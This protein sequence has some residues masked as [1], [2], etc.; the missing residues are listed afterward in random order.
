MAALYAAVCACWI[1]QFVIA[2]RKSRRLAD[3]EV[4]WAAGE[5]AIG[6]PARI[7]ARYT[8][9]SSLDHLIAARSFGQRAVQ[10]GT[11]GVLTLDDE[12]L[13]WAPRGIWSPVGTPFTIDR[14]RV[15]GCHVDG[16]DVVV[17]LGRTGLLVLDTPAGPMVAAWAAGRRRVDQSTS[18]S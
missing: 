8:R 15:T 6:V 12:S 18:R 1:G 5:R 4:A 14:H 16:H 9:L 11:A 17:R 13:T 10:A 7:R 2:R 3:A